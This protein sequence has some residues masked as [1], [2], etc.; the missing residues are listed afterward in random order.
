MG[1]YQSENEERVENPVN[2]ELQETIEATAAEATETPADGEVQALREELQQAQAKAN[3]YLDGWQRA[4]ADFANYKKRIERDQAQ[5]H[6]NAAGNIIKRYLDILDDLDRAMKNRPQSGD[7]AA[8]ANGIELIY[9]KF[10]SVLES[11][12]VETM[13]TEGRPFD[14]NLHEAISQ[15]ESP[16]HESGTVIEV[17]QQGYRLGDRVLRPARVRIA[18]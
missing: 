5:V 9:R 11:E 7:G 1:E 4:R 10:Q 15:D 8:W 12:G 18:K 3:E 14:P 16:E 6:Q 17:V 2:P 13:E